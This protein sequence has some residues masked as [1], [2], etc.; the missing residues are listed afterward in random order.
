MQDNMKRH[1]VSKKGVSSPKGF[2]N[3]NSPLKDSLHSLSNDEVDYDNDISVPDIKISS[4]NII[5]NIDNNNNDNDNNN[6]TNI[7]DNNNNNNN[8]NNTITYPNGD[9]YTGNLVN[10]IKN[11]HGTLKY[12]STGAIYTG[13]FKDDMRNGNGRTIT[14]D[15]VVYEGKYLNDKKQG[16]GVLTTPL[17]TYK[18]EFQN[19]E[20]EGYGKLLLKDG[21]VYEGEWK[22][23][24]QHGEGIFVYHMGNLYDG[25]IKISNLF[26]YYKL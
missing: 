7:K 11:G 2:Y 8:N 24:F 20:R 14:L 4:P 13:E 19:D 6:N 10:S 9:E 3:N 22:N 12:A 17:F 15:S 16:Y 18:G 21:D 1:L 5:S 25:Y 23:G 26:I